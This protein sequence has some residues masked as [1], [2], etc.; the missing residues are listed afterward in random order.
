MLEQTEQDFIRLGCFPIVCTCIFRLG[1]CISIWN[2]R[3]Q[4]PISCIWVFRMSVLSSCIYMYLLFQVV[5]LRDCLFISI[6]MMSTL[7]K[8]A[9]T[10]NSTI[11]TL[12]SCSNICILGLST[13]RSCICSNLRSW[14]HLELKSWPLDWRTNLY[15]NVDLAISQHSQI[16]QGCCK[17]TKSTFQCLVF[18]QSRGQGRKSWKTK[19]HICPLL[20]TRIRTLSPGLEDNYTLKC[21]CIS[22]FRLWRICFIYIWVSLGYLLL[23]PAYICFLG[24]QL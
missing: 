23:V 20:S 10:C 19:G 6:F 5:P 12:S 2:I 14:L 3:W 9:F 21:I 16:Y 15:S 18:L 22:I 11:T 1:S 7:S 13:C 8:C 24:C 4:A 17:N